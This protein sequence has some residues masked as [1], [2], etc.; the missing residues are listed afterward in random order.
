MNKF[1]ER[2]K[3]PKYTQKET[4][5]KN[6][7]IFTKEIVLVQRTFQ[8]QMT[9]NKCYHQTFE[10]EIKSTKTFRKLKSGYYLPNHSINQ[11]YPE[12]KTRNRHFKKRGL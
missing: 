8:A 12:T 6:S 11:H 5:N 9:T 2:Q 1:P 4:N 7:L 3:P 10:E